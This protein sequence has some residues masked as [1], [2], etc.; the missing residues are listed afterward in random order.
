MAACLA[1]VL[2]QSIIRAQQQS[3]DTQ[4][5]NRV[6]SSATFDRIAGSFLTNHCIRCH[7]EDE[8]ESGIRVDQLNGK[9]AE[10]TLKLW[11]EISEQ[12]KTAAMPPEEEPQPS[13]KQRERMVGWIDNALHEARSRTMPINGSVRRLTVQQ[14][15]NALR[16]LLGLEEDF[17]AA[18][19]SDGVSRDGFTN[20]A[21]NFQEIVSRLKRMKKLQAVFLKLRKK[22]HYQD[23]MKSL[24]KF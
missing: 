4:T 19:P 20:D 6:S 3:T 5:A 11:E 23:I 21:E 10:S 8:R 2:N 15:R 18:L 12:I 24:N 7:N 22:L 17:A 14:Y 9:L 1:L 16:E 13:A